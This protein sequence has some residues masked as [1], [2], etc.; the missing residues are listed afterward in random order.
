MR[1]SSRGLTT[2]LFVLVLPAAAWAQSSIAGSVRDT[3]GALLP[4]VTVEAFSDA[5]IEKSRTR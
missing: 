5:L 3:S 4:G 1:K 2:A